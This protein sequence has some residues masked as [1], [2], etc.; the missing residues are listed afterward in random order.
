M[1]SDHCRCRV[2][3]LSGTHFGQRC[4]E[5][6]ILPCSDIEL[7]GIITT[8]SSVNIGKRNG[9]LEIASPSD[10]SS[11]SKETGCEIVKLNETPQA[12]DYLAV[13]NRLKP[14]FVL[15]LGWYYLLPESVLQFAPH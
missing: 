15:V 12:V 1:G 5:E 8:P 2:V 4:L 13:F 3:I 11:I 6:G 7:V 9:K 14:C 10:F